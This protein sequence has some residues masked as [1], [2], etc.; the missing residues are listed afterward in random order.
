M[1]GFLLEKNRNFNDYEKNSALKFCCPIQLP[2]NEALQSILNKNGKDLALN[3]EQHEKFVEFMMKL[4]EEAF[5]ERERRKK[6]R[7]ERQM[8]RVLREFLGK[9]HTRGKVLQKG[10]KESRIVREIAEQRENLQETREKTVENNRNSTK[11]SEFA[12]NSKKMQDFALKIK[13]LKAGNPGK[14]D[15][16]LQKMKKV[17]QC[18]YVFY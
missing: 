6:F 4:N 12:G 9:T 18:E 2:K 10:L 5:Q 1:R 7:T 17:K 11:S 13:R 16:L 8:L 3:A 14:F 15:D